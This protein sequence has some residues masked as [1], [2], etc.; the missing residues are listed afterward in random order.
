MV[1]P[2]WVEVHALDNKRWGFEV[3]IREGRT[4]EIRRLCAALGLEVDRLVRT[5]F[6]P[7]SIGHLPIGE[8]RELLARE[9][10]MIDALLGRI[11]PPAAV[12]PRSR[13]DREKADRTKQGTA[14][15][16]GDAATADRRKKP[17]AKK[18]RGADGPASSK[19]KTPSRSR[20]DAR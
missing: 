11:S 13:R 14:R 19:R 12:R 1:K 17:Y 5:S 6:G 4:R 8:T 20:K 10:H 3:A 18:S 7:V 16:S 2:A 9:R 15:A